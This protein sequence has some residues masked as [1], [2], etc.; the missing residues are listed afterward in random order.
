MP[1]EFSKL[2]RPI[3]LADENTNDE[4]VLAFTA[5]W[6][7]RYRKESDN[8]AVDPT[9]PRSTCTSNE[10]G[11]STFEQ[12]MGDHVN[13]NRI[14][15]PPNS[16]SKCFRQGCPYDVRSQSN[17]PMLLQ[18]VKKG[19]GLEPCRENRSGEVCANH[20]PQA[21]LE[22]YVLRVIIHLDK[23]RPICIIYAT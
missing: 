6:G 14:D 9:N 20:P 1:I 5:G 4:N 12:C 11:P 2:V 10:V 3:C 19:R 17:E 13:C 18:V 23:H 7:M 21:R 15:L 22:P 16:N 8:D